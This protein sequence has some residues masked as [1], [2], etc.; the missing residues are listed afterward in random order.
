MLKLTEKP[1][2]AVKYINFKPQ[3]WHIKQPALQTV[4]PKKM[5]ELGA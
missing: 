1:I 5:L 4:K 2:R 3:H